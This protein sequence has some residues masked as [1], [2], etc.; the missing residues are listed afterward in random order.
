MTRLEWTNAYEGARSSPFSGREGM[1]PPSSRFRALHRRRREGTAF[2]KRCYNTCGKPTLALTGRKTNS[3]CL[4]KARLG[5][6]LNVFGDLL[7]TYAESNPKGE[8]LICGG[9]RITWER[10]NERVNRLADSL[11][12]LGVRKGDKGAL[13]FHN[14]FEFVESACALQ[15][16]GAVPSPLNYRFVSKEIAFQVDHCDATVLLCEEQWLDEVKAA[17]PGMPKV[18]HYVVAGSA[19]EGMLRYEDLV[20]KGSPREPEVEVGPDD[21]ATLIYTGGTTGLPK[22]VV[23]TYRHYMEHLDGLLAGLLVNLPNIRIPALVL[24]V[25]GGRTLGRILGSGACNAF[26][27]YPPVKRFISERAPGPVARFIKRRRGRMP[28]TL[29]FLCVPPLFHMASFGGIMESLWIQTGLFTLV[30]TENPRFDAREVL[31]VIARERPSC[32]WMVPTMWQKLL[33]LEDLDD[34]DLSSLMLLITGAGVCPAKLKAE[35]LRRF[36]HALLLDAFGQ[37]EMTPVATIKIDS[38]AERVRDR[39]VGRSLPGLEVR[40]VDEEGRVLG[41]GEIGEIIYRSPWI[42]EGY[43]KEPE[44]TGEVIRDGWFYSGD[45]GFLDENGEIKVVERKKEVISTGGEKIF[46]HEVEDILEEHPKVERAC[47]VGLPDETYG[48]IPCAVIQLKEGESSTPEE[49]MGWCRGRMAG[50]KRPKVVAFVE[51]LPLNP[52]GK[53]LRAAVKE[54]VKGD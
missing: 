9:R 51:Q 22:G 53:V 47:L 23:T 16:I 39:S 5:A 4:T 49:I 3:D 30:F 40:V 17:M 24:P 32:M 43:Y 10:L 18:R 33:A 48:Q 54:M 12:E 50:Y 29:K 1:D 34:Y 21:V 7:K 2:R 52:M 6:A 35:I 19:P 41:A 37:T 36:R 42:M 26:I 15:K 20:E 25:R 27:R 46:P 45:L 11:R 38:D 31:E 28:V 8:A 13:M 14:C 44:K